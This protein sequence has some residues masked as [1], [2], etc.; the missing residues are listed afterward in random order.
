MG[1]SL[2]GLD[3]DVISATHM[4]VRDR[5]HHSYTGIDAPTSV[6]VSTACIDLLLPKDA[7]SFAGESTP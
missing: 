5:A 3:G 6:F 1:A 4:C 7:G 2:G